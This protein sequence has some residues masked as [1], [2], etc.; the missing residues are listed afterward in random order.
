VRLG[1]G[2]AFTAGPEPGAH[3]FTAL[4]ALVGTYQELAVVRRSVEPGI[5]AHPDAA[6]VVSFPRLTEAD[7]F[8]AVHAGLRLPAGITRFLVSGRVLLLNA[9]LDPLRS[10]QPVERLAEWLA[11]L[12]AGRRADGRVRRYP[13]AVFVL[14]D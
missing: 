5:A 10:D 11:G 8:G 14:D 6:A 3:L 9:A 13:D 4:N 1:D 7:V 12:L 2:R